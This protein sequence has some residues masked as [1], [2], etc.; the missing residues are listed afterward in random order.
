[1]TKTQYRINEYCSIVFGSMLTALSISIFTAPAKIVGG[2][3]SG[4]A[5]ILHHLQGWDIGLVTLAINIPLFFIGV[6]VFGN[7][8]G[9]R[10]FIGTVLLSGFISLFDRIFHN[11]CI[12]DL[13]KDT[14]F[15]LCACF[16]AALS[17]IGLGLVIRG[18]SNTGGT[19][20]IAQIIARFTVLT[21]GL[22]MF[23]VDGVIILISAVFFG[24]EAALYGVLNAYICTVIMDKIVVTLWTNKEKTVYI[25]SSKPEGIERA[26]LEE[27]GHGGT[28]FSAH[29]M[30]SK[31]ERPVIMSVITNHELGRLTKIVH[32]E[33]PK[34][35]MIIQDAF[36]VLGEGFTPIEEAT[37]N[38]EHDVTQK[39]TAPTTSRG[40][41]VPQ[42]FS[43]TRL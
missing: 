34:A 35:F 4:I 17:G 14:N 28:I 29:G 38:D 11:Q 9:V 6:K 40:S 7:Q 10:S 2:G 31:V 21:Q 5:I 37:W 36:E 32:Q 1:M 26:I 19:D 25:I 16:G 13:S 27:L 23:L 24:L 15:L 8:Y 39:P 3:A 41:N 20:I 18:G 30:Y 43:S 33:D 22:S 12:L 42:S